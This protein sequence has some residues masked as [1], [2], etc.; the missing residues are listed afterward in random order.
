MAIRLA[1]SMWVLSL[2]LVTA[3]ASAPAGL[4][5]PE[6]VWFQDARPGTYGAVVE[7]LVRTPADG[8]VLR[9]SV[10]GSLRDGLVVE[11]AASAIVDGERHSRFRLRASPNAS[12]G[13][14]SA[15]VGVRAEDRVVCRVPVSGRLRR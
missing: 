3:C 2:A 10:E 15:V 14:V 1:R 7:L 9:A 8:P 6:A 13:F 12:V 4:V 5:S 11:P